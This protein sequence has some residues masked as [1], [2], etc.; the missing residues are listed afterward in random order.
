MKVAVIYGVTI[1]SLSLFVYDTD[2]IAFCQNL[3]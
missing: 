2:I 1:Y 3:Q